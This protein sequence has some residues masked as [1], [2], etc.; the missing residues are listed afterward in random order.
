MVEVKDKV[1]VNLENTFKNDEYSVLLI[2]NVSVNLQHF[3]HSFWF[4]LKIWCLLIIRSLR[5]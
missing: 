3:F 2:I 4:I 1:F 5:D